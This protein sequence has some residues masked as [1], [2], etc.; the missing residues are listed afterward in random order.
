MRIRG[1][2]KRNPDRRTDGGRLAAVAR[3]MGTPLIPWQR[4][5]ADVACEID[6]DTGSFYYDTVVVSASPTRH[7]RERTPKTT[8]RNTPRP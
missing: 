3:M 4:Y 2:T 7:R 8:S 5:V 6:P 1:G